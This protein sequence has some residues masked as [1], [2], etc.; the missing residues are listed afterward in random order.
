VHHA[1]AVTR[2]QG[3][4]GCQLRT[5][6]A[7]LAELAGD[8]GILGWRPPE[9]LRE[10]MAGEIEQRFQG[11]AQVGVASGHHSAVGGE[12][13][14]V[15][16]RKGTDAVQHS[17]NGHDLVGDHDAADEARTHG[18]ASSNACR[19][20]SNGSRSPARLKT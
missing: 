15:V 3:Q 5:D 7:D 16:E 4:S 6:N 19:C 18:G 9:A 11:T 2:H 8:L 14:E 20:R 10:H 12:R 17:L 13:S 1:I